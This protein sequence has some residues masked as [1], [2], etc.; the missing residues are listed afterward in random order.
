MSSQIICK[1]GDSSYVLQGGGGSLVSAQDQKLNL[2]TY[3]RMKVLDFCY[4]LI[5]VTSVMVF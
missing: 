3:L 1:G 5:T 4:M 2:W